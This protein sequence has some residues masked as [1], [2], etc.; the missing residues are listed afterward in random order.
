M[1]AISPLR[2]RQLHKAMVPIM[3]VPLLITLISGIGFQ[4]AIVAGNGSEFIWLMEL[5]RGKFGR[6][7]LEMIYPFLNGLGLLTLVITGGLMWWRSPSRPSQ[8]H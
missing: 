1:K 3:L 5:H 2:L 6:I 7:N 4:T 8:K